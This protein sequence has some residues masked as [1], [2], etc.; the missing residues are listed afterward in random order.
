MQGEIQLA[1]TAL[2]SEWQ[3]AISRMN[4]EMQ[5]E[6]QLADTTLQGEYGLANTALGQE[7]ESYM[8]AQTDYMAR[9]A[10]FTNM[11]SG[12]YDSYLNRLSD[13][14]GMNMDEAAMDDAYK[15]LA[16]QASDM[17]GLIHDLYPD[18]EPIPFE[19]VQPS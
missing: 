16:Y 8:Q 12:A 18:F 19:I 1:N 6:Y 5:G 9:E 15:A 2:G 17:F 7:W 14:N 3:A 13:L 4:N 11:I 10:N